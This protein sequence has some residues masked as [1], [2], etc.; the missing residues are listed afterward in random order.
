MAGRLTL[1]AALLSLAALAPTAAGF[2]DWK[3]CGGQA[4]PYFSASTVDLSPDP[5]LTGEHLRFKITGTTS[6]NVNGGII[7]IDIKYMGM[8]IFSEV[9]NLCDK[10]ACPI[11]ANQELELTYVEKIPAFV[12]PGKYDITI[13][14]TSVDGSGEPSS[15]L[16]LL[17]LEIETPI[18]SKSNGGLLSHF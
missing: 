9:K 18:N 8:F 7:N 1:A 15:N 14:V 6:Q 10:T 13:T 16:V 4:S 11:P 12:P 2:D 5:P 17:C 3:Y